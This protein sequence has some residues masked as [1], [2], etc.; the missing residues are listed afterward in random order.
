[1]KKILIALA[2]VVLVSGLTAIVFSPKTAGY[3]IY[4]GY[5]CNKAKDYINADKAFDKALKLNP[6]SIV[7]WNCKGSNYQSQSRHAEAL[8]TFNRA[9]AIKTINHS[10]EVA[11][12]QTLVMKSESLNKLARYEA[13]ISICD[14]YLGRRTNNKNY[15]D[16]VAI[17]LNK[18]F[19][20]GRLGRYKQAL[21]VYGTNTYMRSRGYYERA[22]IYSLMRD[23]TKALADLNSAVHASGYDYDDG[24]KVYKYKDLARVAR[25]FEWLWD[26]IGFISI[27]TKIHTEWDEHGKELAAERRYEEAIDKYNE[28]I[29]LGNFEAHVNKG[30]A[31][32]K[33]GRYDE[34]I[35]EFSLPQNDRYYKGFEAVYGL[36]CTYSL[37][38]D[39]SNVLTYLRKAIIINPGKKPNAR[40]DPDFQWL[41][42]DTEFRKITR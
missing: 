15:K 34:A 2:V 26:D 28:A 1:M 14:E 41:W 31:C 16:E 9:L 7:A 13:A 12:M 39:R 32:L 11:Q 20:Y 40:K 6:K 35:R 22:C 42:D 24:N 30:Y 33:L 36:A 25:D 10:D 29:R 27:T 19:A 8:D 4:T 38:G 17:T 18:A 3:W 21:S 37:K 23:K 5:N